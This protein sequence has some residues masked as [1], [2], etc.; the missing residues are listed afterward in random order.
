MANAVKI[1]FDE[2]RH[3]YLVNGQKYPNV[4]SII[5][6]I[7]G[8]GWQASRWYLDR[9]RAVHACAAFIVLGKPFKNDP[10]IDGHV[11]ALRKFISDAKPTFDYGCE[12]MRVVSLRYRFAGTIDLIC[13]IG[14][15]N[16]ILDWKN[17]I[18]KIRLPLQLGGYSQAYLE[19]TGNEFNAG[20][21]VELHENGTYAM[22]EK[23]NLKISRLEFLALRTAYRI[24]E[25]CGNLST[26]KI[27]K[28]S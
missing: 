11:A 6:E 4:T 25:R 27:D 17:S 7:V 10:R 23:I 26:Q 22:S 18:D 5:S 20:Y 8:H 24:K 3:E 21:G 12:E 19:T 15:N 28:Q 16:C 13:K 2:A 9:G 1:D 14:N